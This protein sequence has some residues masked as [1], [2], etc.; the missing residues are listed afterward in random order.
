VVKVGADRRHPLHHASVL[1]PPLVSSPLG[2]VLASRAGHAG[3]RG[4]RRPPFCSVSDGRRQCEPAASSAR[5]QRPQRLRP[6]AQGTEGKSAGNCRSN[7]TQ[8]RQSAGWRPPDTWRRPPAVAAGGQP[9]LQP[10][11]HRVPK[12]KAREHPAQTP[13]GRRCRRTPHSKN[14]AVAADAAAAATSSGRVEERGGVE[15]GTGPGRRPLPARG[16][17]EKRAHCP[18]RTSTTRERLQGEPRRQRPL[19]PPEP[20]GGRAKKAPALPRAHEHHP[21]EV[22]GGTSPAAASNTTR[23][24]WGTSK[25]SARKTTGAKC[26]RHEGHA[27][28]SDASDDR[29]LAVRRRGNGCESTHERPWR[30]ARRGRVLPHEHEH[31]T[32][33]PTRTTA[34]QTTARARPTGRWSLSPES[35]RATSFEARQGRAMMRGTA[36]RGSRGPN[37]ACGSL[38]SWLVRPTRSGCVTPPRRSCRNSLTSPQRRASQPCCGSVSRLTPARRCLPRRLTQESGRARPAM[39]GERYMG[40]DNARSAAGPYFIGGQNA[41]PQATIGVER[42]PLMAGPTISLAALL[43]HSAIFDALLTDLRRLLPTLF[44]GHSPN[45]SH[46]GWLIPL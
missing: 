7:A 18:A 3:H 35:D 30:R 15:G 2:L 27:G 22:A 10:P 37:A 17:D 31:A 11:P 9:C 40:R 16:R 32:S 14:P 23:T 12:Q 39:P 25:K 38:A 8:Q 4:Q 5:N 45:L 46:H 29:W 13:P 19:T 33:H 28:E 21:R 43:A 42:L 26:M 36:G 6:P 24:E 34:A 41:P 44:C 1:T 20:N